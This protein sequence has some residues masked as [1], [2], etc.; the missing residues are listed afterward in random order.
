MPKLYEYITKH[1]G[2]GDGA[3]VLKDASADIQFYC[4]DSVNSR[5]EIRVR[6][7]SDIDVVP[8]CS[9]SDM[10]A[11]D[12]RRFT[13]KDSCSIY[14]LKFPPGDSFH[15][16]QDNWLKSK[17]GN[18][19]GSEVPCWEAVN[20]NVPAELVS[21]GQQITNF[22]RAASAILVGAGRHSFLLQGRTVDVLMNM[23]GGGVDVSTRSFGLTAPIGAGFLKSPTKR[24]TRSSGVDVNEIEALRAECIPSKIL[25]SHGE[26]RMN[27]LTPDNS[28][29]LH[30][31]DIELGKIVSTSTFMRDGVDVPIV[32]IAQSYKSA[33]MDDQ[34][35]LLAL[36]QTTIGRWDTRVG[37]CV[38]Q[39]YH[40]AGLHYVTG[41]EPTCG[42]NF[43]CM[44]TS[45]NGNVAV[46]SRNGRIQLY[47]S[48]MLSQAKTSIPGLGAPITAIDVTYDDKWLLAT[49]DMYLMLMKTTY[50]AKLAKGKF[51]WI[52]EDGHSESWV[53]AV[54]GRFLVVW[55]FA[56][57]RGSSTKTMWDYQLYAA[58][59]EE[60]EELVD[61]QFM[62]S[63][64][65]PGNADAGDAALLVATPHNLSSLILRR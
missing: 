61:V 20:G 12:T 65:V 53:V 51:T 13:F 38:V 29:I 11:P 56:K 28:S 35:Q 39:E 58:G 25:L 21:F 6:I 41:N 1:E 52:T 34:V 5:P 27:F 3:W 40:S 33:Q 17:Y 44:A 9:A 36:N 62:H 32:E 19:F 8:S 15:S 46:G 31:A 16:F 60:G 22:T 55:D 18:V 4:V 45:G 7:G 57:I 54:C 14:S 24:K 50:G 2:S 30:H 26:K 47:N 63:K 64:Y 23:E 10:V 49:T 43:T 48:R 37:T 59:G 42:P